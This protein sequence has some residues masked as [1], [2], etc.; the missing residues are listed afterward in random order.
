MAAQSTADF[1]QQVGFDPT[2]QQVRNVT[3]IYQ[4]GGQMVKLIVPL[5][6][7]VPIPALE[8]TQITINFK[9]SINASASQAT[10]TAQSADVAGSLSGSAQVGWGPFSAK[11]NFSASVS[12]KSSSKATQD[13]RYSVE[14]TQEIGVTA[15]QAGMPAGLATVLNI[16]S[17]AATGTSLNGQVQAS[18]A[19]GTVSLSSP[20]QMQTVQVVL[21]DA[22]GLNVVNAPV[23][24]TS[25]VYQADAATLGFRLLSAGDATDPLEAVFLAQAP[26]GANPVRLSELEKGA[27]TFA[28][29][30]NGALGLL[31]WVDPAR[32]PELA[33]HKFDLTF[34][35]NVGTSAQPNV[36]S[37]SVPFAVTGTLPTPLPPGKPAL[38]PE[39]GNVNIPIKAGETVKVVVD[40]KNADGSNVPD[41]TAVTGSVDGAL[42]DKLNDPGIAKT[43]G[44]KASFDLGWKSVEGVTSGQTATLTF[45]ATIQGQ[46]ATATATVTAQTAQDDTHSSPGG[47]TLLVSAGTGRGHTSDG[48]PRTGHSD[49]GRS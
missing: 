1:I 39:A 44:G 46:A 38:D 28:T 49:P 33:G 45:Q 15:A 13:S 8:I 41:D 10:E 24:I 30:Q 31:V 26:A 17:N 42:Q 3:F 40:A 34:S 27:S 12:S 36:Q 23:T 35:A 9:A 7:I 14:Y 19:L 25:A 6:S 29:D 16:L 32:A 11:V 22:N 20:G 47:G 18:P 5:L 21:T 43:Q 37:V 2:T 48:G 4:R